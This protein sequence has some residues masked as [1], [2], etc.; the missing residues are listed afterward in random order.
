MSRAAWSYIAGSAGQQQTDRENRLALDRWKI[1]PRMLRDISSRDMRVELFGHSLPAPLL[2]APIGALG[3]VGA[4]AD[5]AAAR[6]ARRLGIPLIISTQASAP[7]ERTAAVLDRSPR[8]FQLYWSG[9]D[10]L[11][12]SFVRRAE[13]I[14]A[15]VIVVTLDTQMLGWR[16]ADRDIGSLPF[17]RGQGIAQYTSDPVFMELVA[18]RVSAPPAPTQPRPRPTPGALRTLASLARTHPGPFANNL[19]SPVPRA[20]VETFLELF[21]R[22]SLTWSDLDW[23]RQR[24]KLPIVLKGIVDPRDAQLALDHGVDGII[25]SNHGGRQVDG[26]I[27]ALTVLPEIVELASG[28]IPVLFDSGIRGGADVFKALALGATAVGIGRPWVYGLALDGSAGAI[29]VLRY[30]MAELDITMA[31]TGCTSLA[32]VDGSLL[33]E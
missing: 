10:E 13:A 23:L 1:V 16:T 7:R 31:L 29:A 9:S 33:R 22:P 32:E 21:S 25:V 30:L 28:R 2:L 6:A 27:G 12:E 18:R 15:S 8:W 3:M 17:V 24:T 14:G 26:A 11:N 4:D 5:L 19:R 20:A